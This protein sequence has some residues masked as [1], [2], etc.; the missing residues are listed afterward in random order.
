MKANK[1]LCPTDFSHYTDAA[2]TYASSLAAESGATLYIAHVDEFRD[3]SATLGEAALGYAS[4]WSVMDRSE[5]RNQLTQVTP[6]VPSVQFEHR[7]LVGSP[8]REIV[9]F[10][11]RE[12]VDLIVMGSHGRT[13]LSRMLMGSVAEGVARRAPCPVLIVK[14]P[15]AETQEHP[16]DE[17]MV[18]QK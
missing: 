1:I 9:A 12:H 14:Q 10:A 11:A 7:Y 18:L 15:I 17:A 13:G 4:P 8:V 5:V 6:T 2:L 3:T 16:S